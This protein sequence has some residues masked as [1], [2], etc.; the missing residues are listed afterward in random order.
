MGLRFW[1]CSITSG[2]TAGSEIC[3]ARDPGTG[4]QRLLELWVY[5]ICMGL[6]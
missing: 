3:G 1:V 2:P 4:D 5:G 6:W